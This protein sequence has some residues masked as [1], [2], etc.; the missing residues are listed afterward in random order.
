MA[1]LE[2]MMLTN[3]AEAPPGGL[4]YVMGGAWDTLTVAAPLEGAPP[5]VVSVLHHYLLIRLGFHMTETG[6]DHA[7]T[8]RL[9]DADGQ[10]IAE[11]QG[12]LRVDRAPG[13]PPSWPQGSNVVIPLMGLGLPKWGEYEFTV[14]VDGTFMGSR[15]FRVIKAY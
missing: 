3:Y 1:E 7:F 12:N 8:I 5:G 6:R 4:V 15:P 10:Q 13:L 11:I 9:A 14:N 2:W